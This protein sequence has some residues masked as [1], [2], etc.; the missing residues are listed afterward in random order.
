M[1]GSVHFG[2]D[3]WRARLDEDFNDENVVRVADALGGVW[4]RTNP[5]ATVYVGYDTRADAARFARLAGE[6]IA[7]HGLVVTVSERHCPAPALSWTVAHDRS[8]CGGIMLT[9]AHNPSE[10]QG[11]KVRMADGGAAPKEFTDQLEMAID[12]D[13]TP[14]RGRVSF[15]DIVSPYLDDLISLVDADAI[16]SAQ[17]KVVHDPMYGATRGY[18]A[19]ALRRLGVDVVEIHAEDA[20]DFNDLHPEPVEP[21]VDECEAAV[22]SERA[23]IGLVNDGGGA[24]AAAIDEKGAFIAPHKVFCLIMQHLVE[25]RGKSG[26]AVVTVS[27]SVMAMRQ[28]KRLGCPV[29]VVPVGFK[30]IYGE[31]LK[32]D[33]LLGGEESGGIGIPDHLLERDG[34][35][36]N[37]LLCELVA[38]TGK[39]LGQLVAEL[40]GAVGSMHYA[41]RDLRL[42]VEV[43]ETLKMML[44]GMNPPE[45]AGMEPVEVSHKDGLRITF[46]DGAWLLL[47]PSDTEQVV[48][49][50]AEAASVEQRDALLEAG[51]SAARSSSF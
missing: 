4:E 3:G 10:Y 45:V 22:V 18:M 51:V 26:R 5:G 33:V 12:S 48:R 34:M 39:T 32:G 7:S 19:D 25:N 8:A 16:S 36:A 50:H 6:V 31:M 49:V 28:A 21:W 24:R 44:P 20:A 1:I 11:F 43:I 17:L 46:E 9:A 27:S 2:T 13:A 47:R 14:R 38:K 40:E 15:Q 30:W 37:L 41:R 35:L 23:C 29:T 42:P